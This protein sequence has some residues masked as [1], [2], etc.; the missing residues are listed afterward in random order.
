MMRILFASAL[1]AVAALAGCHSSPKPEP[2]SSAAPSFKVYKLRGKVVSTNPATGEVTW[3]MRPFP[4]SW[5]R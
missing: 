1:L 4:A 3:I 2:Q 5:M